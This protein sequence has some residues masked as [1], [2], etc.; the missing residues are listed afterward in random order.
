M[1]VF[2]GLFRFTYSVIVGESVLGTDF[3]IGRQNVIYAYTIFLAAK[4]VLFSLLI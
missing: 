3:Y 1:V 2:D 4:P